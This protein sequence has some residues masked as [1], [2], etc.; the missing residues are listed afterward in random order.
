M[1]HIHYFAFVFSDRK[2]KTQIR[3]AYL[4][5]ENYFYSFQCDRTQLT[6]FDFAR[7][8]WKRNCSQLI[9]SINHQPLRTTQIRR[10]F[11]YILYSV[12]IFNSIWLPDIFRGG[13][14]IYYKLTHLCLCICWPKFSFPNSVNVNCMSHKILPSGKSLLFS[15]LQIVWM[16][17]LKRILSIFQFNNR[18]NGI[19]CY[20]GS[21]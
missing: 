16:I 20:H 7:T 17:C 3:L 1:S 15:S 2:K 13:K 14:H 8:E 10:Y 4:S 12:R 6:S 5:F 21:L 11:N 9:N 18:I 19:F